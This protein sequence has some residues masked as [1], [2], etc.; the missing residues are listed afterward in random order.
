MINLSYSHH[1][2][3]SWLFST[4]NTCQL[5]A[6]Y[7]RLARYPIVTVS[8]HCVQQ[9]PIGAPVASWHNFCICVDTNKFTLMGM[10]IMRGHQIPMILS[11]PTRR[12]LVGSRNHHLGATW[13]DVTHSTRC[14]MVLKF[15]LKTRK[16]R[17]FVLCAIY[18]SS[19]LPST[20]VLI[21]Y[22]IVGE[23]DIVSAATNVSVVPTTYHS[24]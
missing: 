12:T 19:T 20:L 18:C 3:V 15:V 24:C 10:A 14:I 7:V 4:N 16:W 23:T 9:S 1:L 5:I 13:P 17:C 22:W 2:S 8:L 21:I 6:M 11:G